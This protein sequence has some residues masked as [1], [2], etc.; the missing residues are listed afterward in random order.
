MIGHVVLKLACRYLRARWVVYLSVMAVA[1]ALA[2]IIFVMSLQ[3]WMVEMNKRSIR[4][5]L[6]DV[7]VSTDHFDGFGDYTSL[8]DRVLAVENVQAVAV[9][10]EFRAVA[11]TRWSAKPCRVVGIEV[12]HQPRVGAIKSFVRDDVSWSTIERAFAEPGTPAPAIV[13]TQ[14]ARSLGVD[15][16]SELLAWTATSFVTDNSQQL[17]MIAAMQSNSYDFD[18]SV[19]YVPLSVA[20]QFRELPD[21]AS[22]LYVKLHDNTL[23]DETVEAI[24]GVIDPD[25]QPG[26]TVGTWQSRQAGF[27]EALDAE[28]LVLNLVL[29]LF[30]GISAFSVTAIFWMIVLS[31][32]RDIGIVR[33]MGTPV[34][35]VA[36]SF[37][38]FGV[39]V[40]VVAGGIG[41]A[42]GHGVVANWETVRLAIEGAAGWV[43][44]DIQLH[45][46]DPS[47][48]YIEKGSQ[49]DVNLQ[50]DLMMYGLTVVLCGMAGVLPSLRAART[51][52]IENVKG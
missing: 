28:R 39:L 51:N 42:V 49:L 43:G 1:A 38:A 27:I 46:F 37:I 4:G 41:F 20:Q 31:K 34:T 10:M 11:S 17:Q 36:L 24:R 13:G 26:V 3:T 15:R 16:G 5:T 9:A 29:L 12:S 23:A 8:R 40:G 33:A 7:I 45:L 50:R 44:L 21:R 2:G 30:L 52:V 22:H 14:L 25:E 6:S 32:Q 48:Y 18:R 35:G 19:V 47:L